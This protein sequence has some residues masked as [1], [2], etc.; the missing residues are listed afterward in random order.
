MV[1]F[2]GNFDFSITVIT[3]TSQILTMLKVYYFKPKI[4]LLVFAN[5]NLEITVRQLK[6]S[7][8][9]MCT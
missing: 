3:E 9:F 1:I 6:G 5:I 7:P 8:N 4:N 2:Y